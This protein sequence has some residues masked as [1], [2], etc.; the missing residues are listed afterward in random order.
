MTAKTWS[1][2]TIF[3]ASERTPVVVVCESPTTYLILYPSAAA[4]PMPALTPLIEDANSEAAGP[5]RSVSTPTVY[6]FDPPP[7]AP[8]VELAVPGLLLHPAKSSRT[9]HDSPATST[10]FLRSGMVSPLSRV[11]AARSP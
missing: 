2:C 4:T 9:M 6:V 8:V 3:C 1:C 7:P 5:D 10:L 11:G